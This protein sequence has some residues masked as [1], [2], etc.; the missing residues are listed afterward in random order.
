MLTENQE[1]IYRRNGSEISRLTKDDHIDDE[2]FHPNLAA[3]IRYYQPFTK[4]GNQLT[5]PECQEK[6]IIKTSLIEHVERKNNTLVVKTLNSSYE[7]EYK[8]IDL[9][10]ILEDGK[11]SGVNKS[12][13]NEIAPFPEI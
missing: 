2:L 4:E 6:K 12:E 10:K 1:I 8:G 13:G 5:I 11:F 3:Y 7:I 9:K